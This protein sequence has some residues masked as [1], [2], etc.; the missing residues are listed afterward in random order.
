[1]SPATL[2]LVMQAAL[3]PAVDDPDA[4]RIDRR[5]VE[6]AIAEGPG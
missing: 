1:M 3:T 2:L 5:H 6:P 4:A